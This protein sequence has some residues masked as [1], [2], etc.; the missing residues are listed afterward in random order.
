MD[1]SK[2]LVHEKRLLEEDGKIDQGIEDR[3]KE[4]HDSKGK[5]SAGVH[6]KSYTI[7]ELSES[8]TIP[9]PSEREVALSER[10][11]AKIIE[12]QKIIENGVGNMLIAFSK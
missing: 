1:E 7:L 3:L 9:E 5:V 2:R 8:F 10:E 12:R 11:V 6:Y 4:L